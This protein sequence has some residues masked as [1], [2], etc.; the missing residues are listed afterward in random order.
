MQNNLLKYLA[1]AFY[2]T[3]FA[4]VLEQKGKYTYGTKF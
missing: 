3:I 4:V 1:F 2:R